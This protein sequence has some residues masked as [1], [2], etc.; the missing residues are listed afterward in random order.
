MSS[1]RS[2]T[3]F[4]FLLYENEQLAV[5]TFKNRLRRSLSLSG[6]IQMTIYTI[7][8]TNMQNADAA[9]TKSKYLQVSELGS[10]FNLSFSSYLVFGNKII[11]LDGVKKSL[12]ILETTGGTNQSFIIELNKMEAVTVKKNYGSIR[13]GQLKKKGIEDFL[14]SIDLEFSN[15][16]ET[17]VLSFY[18][19]ETDDLL[20][21]PKL[22]RNAKNWQA[23]LSK[24]IR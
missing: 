24:M 14:K 12:L 22:E 18:N 16:T 21:L 19:S 8:L 6:A 3:Q 20:Q 9:I 7:N 11:A 2:Y 13:A 17:I 4:A 23:I 10:K 15:K 1:D 5:Y